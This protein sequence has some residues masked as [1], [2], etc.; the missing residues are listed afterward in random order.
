MIILG[1]ESSCDETAV[2][3]L[4]GGRRVAAARVAGQEDIHSLYGGVVP[5]LASRRHLEVIV[6]LCERC[7]AEAGLAPAALGAVAA[8]TRPGLSGALMVGEAFARAAAGA[9][10]IPFIAIDH[11][12]AHLAVNF[13]G[14]APALPAL[15]LVVSGGH[16]SLYLVSAPNR[17]RLLGETRDDA[18]GET[19]DKVARALGLPYPGG[20]PLEKLA[21]GAREP[22]VRFP[23]PGVRDS[24]DFSFSGLKT[25]VIYHLDRE[26]AADRAAVAAGFQAAVAAGLTRNLAYAVNRH[27]VRSV[28]AGGGVLANNYLRGRLEKWAAGRNIALHVPVLA[29]CLDNAVMVA[30]RAWFEIQPP[31]GS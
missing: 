3:L 22:A 5:E 15:G 21:A 29:E 31:G 2:A 11:L 20:P 14:A 13:L 10:G 19:F 17:Y 18:A 4:D 30:V 27:Q 24:F 12:E 28:I 25:A 16:S 6:P 8:S 23:P 26:P 7:F 9:L 1:I